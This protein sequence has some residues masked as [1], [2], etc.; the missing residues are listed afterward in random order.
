VAT[1]KYIPRSLL[2]ADEDG[3]VLRPGTLAFLDPLRKT[4]PRRFSVLNQH[5]IT[6]ESLDRRQDLVTRRKVC[7]EVGI[8]ADKKKILLAVSREN[9]RCALAES[10][11][12]VH[13]FAAFRGGQTR[14]VRALPKATTTSSVHG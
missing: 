10:V 12:Q 13:V 4:P 3:L 6:V 9:V 7:G 8:N 1:K 5:G 14:I 2:E 11:E